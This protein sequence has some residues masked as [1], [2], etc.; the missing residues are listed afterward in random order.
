MVLRIRFWF[1]NMENKVVGTDKSDKSNKNKSDTH[2]FVKIAASVFALYFSSLYIKPLIEPVMAEETKITTPISKNAETEEKN[3]RTVDK[4]IKDQEKAVENREEEALKLGS[5]KIELF[6]RITNIKSSDMQ[7]YLGDV[8]FGIWERCSKEGYL[9]DA[10]MYYNIAI[11]TADTKESKGKYHLKKAEA[12]KKAQKYE[13]AIR[14]YLKAARLSG[15][16]Q[17]IILSHATE[18]ARCLSS[19]KRELT[20]FKINEFGKALDTKSGSVIKP[21]HLLVFHLCNLLY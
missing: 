10:I 6:S 21:L 4:D 2:K 5:N 19:P 8:Y 16:S 9:K 14:E 17:G 3:Q 15:Y 11:K 18:L 7:M 20:I 12:Y 13:D 1:E